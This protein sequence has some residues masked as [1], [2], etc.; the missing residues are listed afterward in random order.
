MRA[1]WFAW[2]F[3]C[4]V[5]RTAHGTCASASKANLTVSVAV[6]PIDANI[7]SVLF[8]SPASTGNAGIDLQT[9]PCAGR[10][11]AFTNAF[12]DMQ[13]LVPPPESFSN[14]SL[15]T[16]VSR[17][18]LADVAVDTC[19]A[20]TVLE[21]S[22]MWPALI[23]ENIHVSAMVTV[24]TN[25]T[26]RLDE[27]FTAVR[28]FTT[29]LTNDW[30]QPDA[31]TNSAC[32]GVRPIYRNNYMIGFP[33]Y[34]TAFVLPEGSGRGCSLLDDL[35]CIAVR[36][37]ADFP[38]SCCG[39]VFTTTGPVTELGNCSSTTT[40]TTTA[41]TTPTT[42]TVAPDCTAPGSC[43]TTATTTPTT[44]ATSTVAPNCAGPTASALVVPSASYTIGSV[45]VL[46]NTT[47]NC[48][49]RPSEGGGASC[50][51][52]QIPAWNTDDDL[53]TFQTAAWPVPKVGGDSC[54]GGAQLLCT[55]ERKQLDFRANITLADTWSDDSPEF[56]FVS[57]GIR[58]APS[59][60]L[61][62]VFPH[63]MRTCVPPSAG[64]CYGL[65]PTI[66][67]TPTGYAAE[68]DPNQVGTGS[69]CIAGDTALCNGIV[70]AAAVDSCCNYTIAASVQVLSVEPCKVMPPPPV[71]P[72]PVSP[73][74]TN[75][76]LHTRS[77]VAWI[78]GACLVL[79]TL[80]LVARYYAQVRKING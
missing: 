30:I 18:V 27:D 70:P 48:S 66:I 14:Q 12:G 79:I 16:N 26:Y 33:E 38:T 53:Q 54:T 22:Q 34:V 19:Q 31:C 80:V 44:T 29:N 47:L 20:G 37:Q 52:L 40:G 24:V 56:S 25:E 8:C 4:A 71:P 77:V 55:A 43:T 67:K 45:Q 23:V 50:N 1:M 75:T 35:A 17:F 2:I 58:I 63:Q 21:C 11:V 41:T 49:K 39:V 10:S 3:A 13:R 5:V 61:L 36:T 28:Q 57:S 15:G 51:N 62:D 64:A 7:S 6:G 72:P 68:L 32:T 73:R 46:I 76:T 78:V 60:P 74:R 69:F 9:Y 59:L 65:K 42:T